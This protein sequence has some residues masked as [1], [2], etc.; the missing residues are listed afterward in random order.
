L[1]CL[2]AARISGTLLLIDAK[3]KLTY[4]PRVMDMIAGLTDNR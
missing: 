3:R 4:E 2:Q 1:E